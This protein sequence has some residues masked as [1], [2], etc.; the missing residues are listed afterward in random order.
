[1]SLHFSRVHLI[2]S[3]VIEVRRLSSFI[4]ICF[5]D[6]LVKD[7]SIFSSQYEIYAFLPRSESGLS[8]PPIFLQ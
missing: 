3:S 8:G 2:S 6:I 1:M 5:V 4:V 7:S